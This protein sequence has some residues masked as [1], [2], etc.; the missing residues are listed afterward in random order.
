[1]GQQHK[2]GYSFIFSGLLIINSSNICVG[3]YVDRSIESFFQVASWL[4]F[5]PI[6]TGLGL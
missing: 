1:M 5:C 3:S 4:V 2:L 6:F